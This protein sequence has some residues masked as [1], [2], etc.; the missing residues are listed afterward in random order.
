MNQTTMHPVVLE[1]LQKFKRRRNNL[2]L[3]RGLFGTIATWIGCMVLVA[4]ADRFI[5]LEDNARIALSLIGDGVAALVFWRSCGRFL[6]HMPDQR[7]L[8]RLIEVAAPQ[9]REELLAA[10]ELSG[11]KG[12]AGLDSPAFRAA[13]QKLVADQLGG[14][15]V[16]SLLSR[17]LI[18]RWAYAAGGALALIAVLL[19]VPGLRFRQFLAR[20]MMPTA[21]IERP[22]DIKIEVV[23]PTPPDQI[24]PEG[25]SIPVSVLISGGE[26]EQV[27]LET[28]PEHGRREKFPMTLAGQKQFSAAIQLE[29]QP[30]EFRVRAGDAITRRFLLDP[31]ARP[32]V[33]KF[34]KT[35]RYPDYTQLAPKA[36][37]ED[38]GDLEALEGTDVEIGLEVAPSVRE[39]SL[40]VE[41]GTRTNLIP[42]QIS[43]GRRGV[44]RLPLTASGIYKV[45][46]T[47]RDTGFDNKFSPAYEIRVLPDTRPAVQIVLPEQRQVVLPPDSVVKLEAL[48]K[49]DLS[50]SNIEQ[51]VQVNRGAWQHMPLAMGTGTE[52]QV[53]KSWDLFDLGLHPGDHVTTKLVATDRKGQRGESE[54]LRILVASA[55]FDPKRLENVEKHRVIQKSVRQAREE[56]ERA[57]REMAQARDAVNN[58]GNE[59]AKRKQAVDEASAAVETARQ[60]VEE[61]MAELKAA[62]PKSES[63]RESSDLSLLARAASRM[64][65]ESIPE[66][67]ERLADASSKAANGTQQSAQE[68]MNKA[69]DPL[70]RSLQTV[71]KADDAAS[72]FLSSREAGVA[73]RDLDQLESEQKAINEQVAAGA[74]NEDMK[75]RLARRQE[76]AVDEAKAIEKLLAQ[77]A[78]HTR[79]WPGESAKNQG[80]AIEREREKLEQAVTGQ[81]SLEDMR[82]QARQ[83]EDRADDAGKNMHNVERHLAQESEKR[84]EELEREI[85]NVADQI[86]HLAWRNENKETAKDP[87]AKQLWPAMAEQLR[88]RADIEELRPTPD[89]QYAA[90]AAKAADAMA[91]LRDAA[92]DPTQSTQALRNLHSLADAVKKVEA[93]HK[94]AELMPELRQLAA[95]ERWEKADAAALSER[96]QDWKHAHDRIESVPQAL[97]QAQLPKEPARDLK[98]LAWSEQAKKV[99]EEQRDRENNQ[100]VKANLAEP[101]AT[102][103]AKVAKVNQD[104]QPAL[105]EARAAI[106]AL[107]PA[108]SE[109]L[110]GLAKAAE[111]RKKETDANAQQPADAAEQRPAQEK[112]HE[113]ALAQ[114]QLDEQVDDIRD[115]LRHDANTQDFGTEEGRERARDADDA[116]AMLQQPTPSA[117]DMLQQAAQTPEAAKRENA[118]KAAATEQDKLASTL[119]D[120]AEHYKNLEAG[121]PEATRAALRETE[122]EL[123]I[124]SALDAA[125]AQAEDAQARADQSAADQLAALEKELQN[126]PAMQA[127]LAAIAKDTL[128]D[129]AE[130]LQSSA[131]REGQVADSLQKAAQAGSPAEQ[132]KRI[133]EGARKIAREEIPPTARQAEAVGSESKQ[134]LDQTAQNLENTAN[135]LPTDFSQPAGNLVPAVA[136]QAASLRRA[137]DDLNKAADKLGNKADHQKGEQAQQTRTAQQQARQSAQEASQLAQQAAYLANAL[138]QQ[139]TPM[140]QASAQQPA[141]EGDVRDAGNDVARAGRHEERLGSQTRGE[142][143]QQLGA[144]IENETG[145]VVDQAEGSLAG[146]PTPAAAQPTAEG[147]QDAIE[148]PLEQLQGAAALAARQA[149][150]AAA[151]AEAA[152]ADS[153]AAQWMARALDSL[154]A[155][156]H[157]GSP[158]SQTPASADTQQATASQAMDAAAEAQL[159]SMMNARAQGLTPGQQ[160]ISMA[161][162]E[163]KGAAFSAE[164]MEFGA[165]PQATGITRH[166]WGKLPPKLAKDLMEARRSGVADEYKDM[167]DFYFRAV[168][169]KSREKRP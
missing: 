107:T 122:K 88:D 17:K 66:M 72:N 144:Q 85:G 38:A 27:I 126:N 149:D 98:S 95:E 93:G 92:A 25:D 52:M 142:Q 117:A 163:G 44:V 20:A 169:E 81:K 68:A 155:A 29:T 111:E 26:P 71:R 5:M 89:A 50:L 58:G 67:Q 65:R 124:K 135:K 1:Q 130:Q 161:K 10:V 76:V 118:M 47:G 139:A 54:T 168:A 133:A 138:G 120:L 12:G 62:L 125:Y 143:L 6:S 160:P 145:G 103:A 152:N 33:V 45:L 84:R 151:A 102:L 22:S 136:E 53:A 156:A 74:Q 48:A 140:Q 46:L 34:H 2:I 49:D 32:Q 132:S 80:K 7:E 91:A 110:A 158:A 82:K 77:M 99:M 16:E 59:P 157:P 105:K 37:S 28:F 55:G 101:L 123:G 43:N 23:L 116:S 148:K 9:L 61:M 21:N 134:L 146:A 35:Y 141:I 75:T 150:A 96:K 129:A 40:R 69:F 162:A 3:R 64:L 19:L 41:L 70:W 131:A 73:A 167:V 60:R 112:A 97:E 14:L 18:Q 154:D 94:V 147:A 164:G 4:F 127:E 36:V 165:L 86:H 51:Y 109:R 83:L 56:M 159:A 63:P 106:E 8:A 119:K 79:E 113:L 114:H 13:L 30:I 57:E 121:K 128:S 115:A 153:A 90:D 15:S 104:L 100:E 24:V 39:A 42:V 78:E 137:A 166:E 31:R 11:D 108:L 87:A